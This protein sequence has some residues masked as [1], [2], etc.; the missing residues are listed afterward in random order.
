[1]QP[2][3]QVLFIGVLKEGGTSLQRFQAMQELGHHVVPI[4]TCNP[5]VLVK[6]KQ[7]STRALHRIFGVRDLAHAN[8]QIIE[9]IHKQNFDILW[10][11]KALAIKPET[12]QM[13][14]MKHP[15]CLITGYSPDDMCG[16][17]QNIS[18]HFLRHLPEYDIYFTTKS[19][20]VTELRKLGCR[21]VEFVGNAYDKHYH[22]PI[23][24]S[25]KEKNSLGGTVGFIGTFEQQRGESLRLLTSKGI[26]VRIWGNCWEKCKW[27]HPNC[28]FEYQALI[29]NNYARAICSFDINLC[30]L[31]KLNRDLQTTR[32]VEIPACGA[33]MLAERTNEHL[34][35]FK[36]GKE[37]EFFSSDEELIKKIRYYINHPEKR[38]R[39][40][41]AG[42]QRCLASGYSYH[43]RLQEMLKKVD[44]IRN[45]NNDRS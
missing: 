17:K 7:L 36:E 3:L 39:I 41:E 38:K 18:R 30:F 28:I 2:R 13:V 33:F 37:A 4:D 6:Q 26:V 32:S 10:L 5:E 44:D 45:L 43:D 35:L 16:N 20:N 22:R 15:N 34:E 23:Q 25:E 19:Y 29:G 24:L 42:R 14:R 11:D 21:R 8:K 40:A 1:M 31:R 9:R 12:L 27:Q